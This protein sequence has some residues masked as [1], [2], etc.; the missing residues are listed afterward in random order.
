MTAA[1]YLSCFVS[2]SA[3]AVDGGRFLMRLC[4]IS[5]ILTMLSPPNPSALR[6]AATIATSAPPSDIAD[7]LAGVATGRLVGKDRLLGQPHRG[8]EHPIQIHVSAGQTGEPEPLR[9][10]IGRRRHRLLR[11]GL[12]GFRH[13]L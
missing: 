10:E 6:L 12:L 11:R 3:N 1:V 8:V 2:A 9:N 7:L 4:R 13:R 5:A